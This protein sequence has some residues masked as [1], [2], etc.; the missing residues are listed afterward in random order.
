MNAKEFRKQWFEE[1]GDDPFDSFMEREIAFA[2]AYA[3]SLLP[4]DEE[5]KKAGDDFGYVEMIYETCFE[6]GAK[7]AVDHIKKQI[8]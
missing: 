3:K 7:W 4:S 2:E 6:D 5:R 8:G 1:I